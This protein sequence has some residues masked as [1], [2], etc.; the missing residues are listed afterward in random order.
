MKIL[1]FCLLVWAF[2][3]TFD[4]VS[5]KM[6]LDDTISHNKKEYE[7]IVS[8]K[9]EAIKKLG[10]KGANWLYTGLAVIS[11]LLTTVVFALCVYGVYSLPI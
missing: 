1:L 9:E 3:S 7:E 10:V 2:W 4:D 6:S 5:K 11:A 8:L